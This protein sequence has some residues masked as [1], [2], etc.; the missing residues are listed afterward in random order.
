[1]KDRSSNDI[2]KNLIGKIKEGDTN[3][4]GQLVE[5]Y[6]DV[7]L[8]LVF[9]I[10]KDERLAEDVL[11]EVFIKVYEKLH[12]FKNKSTFSTW[13]YRIVVNSSYN[14]LKKM[15]RFSNMDDIAR[16]PE[17]IIEKEDFLKEENQKRFIHM[18]LNAMQNDEALILRLFYLSEMSIREISKI[19]NF[20]KSK[21]KVCLHRGRSNL[22]FQLRQLLGDELKYL[23]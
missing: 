10:L 22:D 15:K 13:L 8:S 2:D 19:T 11:Q 20:S 4:F 9:S 16:R 6:K 23:L 3:A 12:Q 17:Q 7:S 14:E 5:K 21:V 18:A 1:M